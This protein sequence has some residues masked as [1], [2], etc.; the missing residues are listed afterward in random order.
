MAKIKTLAIPSAGEAAEQLEFAYIAGGN[1]KW[2]RHYENCVQFLIKIN[3]HY[4]MAS[5]PTSISSG[6]MKTSVHTKICL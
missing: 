2:C 1:A 5:N 6:K 3:P 4:A